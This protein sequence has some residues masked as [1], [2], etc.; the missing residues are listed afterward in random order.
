[1]P[2]VCPDSRT[3][4]CFYAHCG[5]SKVRLVND[6]GKYDLAYPRS[7]DSLYPAYIRGLTYLQKG[8]G[9]SAAAEFQKILD[10]PGTWDDL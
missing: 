7:F 6:V 2:E 1:V 8:D 4:T 10:H 9:R 3:E 5:I